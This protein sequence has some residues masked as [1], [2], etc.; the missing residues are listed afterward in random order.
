MVRKKKKVRAENNLLAL[1]SLG[2]TGKTSHSGILKTKQNTQRTFT[3]ANTNPV[4]Y[5]LEISHPIVKLL[6][7]EERAKHS[8]IQQEC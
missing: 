5:T 7:T 6:A 4:C 2:D 3:V 1:S 8:N